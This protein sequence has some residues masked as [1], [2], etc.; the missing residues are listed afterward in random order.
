MAVGNITEADQVNGILMAGRADL[1]CLARPHLAD[2]YWT[3]HAAMEAGDRA[4]AW[5][6]PYHAGRDQAAACA[7]RRPRRSAHDTGGQ[8]RS[9]HRGRHGRGRRPCARLCRRR[10]GGGDRGRRA[11]AL[12]AVAQGNP[13]IR[14]IRPM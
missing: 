7:R 14:P 3:L 5:P 13:R 1:V 2:P 6:A 9:D 8:A 4:T 10:G 12:E 11:T